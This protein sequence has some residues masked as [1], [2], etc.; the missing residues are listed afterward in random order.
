LARGADSRCRAERALGTFLLD[1]ADDTVQ[2]HDGQDGQRL[3]RV[4]QQARD[5]GRCNNDDDDRLED[6]A[7]ESPPHRRRWGLLEL[8]RTQSRLTICDVG[9]I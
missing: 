9:L 2:E 3:A 4:L 8:I 5:G 1:E 7:D 6:L